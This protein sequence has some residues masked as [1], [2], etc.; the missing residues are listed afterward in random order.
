MLSR[1]VYRASPITC[2]SLLNSFAISLH[3][4]IVFHPSIHPSIYLSIYPGSPLRV[5]NIITTWMGGF[6]QSVSLQPYV[7]QPMTLRA[8]PGCYWSVRS[9]HLAAVMNVGW[10]LHHDVCPGYRWL[11][12]CDRPIQSYVTCKTHVNCTVGY[13]HV[14]VEIN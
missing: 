6:W 1:S 5:S 14:L 12:N 10:W 4:H 11:K 2:P 13:M 7:D 8:C 9:V 3:F